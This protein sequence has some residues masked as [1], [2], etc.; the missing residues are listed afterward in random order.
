MGEIALGIIMTYFNIPSLAQ[1]L[2]LLLSSILFIA[3]YNN[4]LKTSVK[5]A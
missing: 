1:L 3:L 4:W 2:H 5:P